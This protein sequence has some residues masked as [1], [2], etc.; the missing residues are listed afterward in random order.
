MVVYD[1]S[2]GAGLPD[3]ARIDALT[4]VSD[5][6]SQDEHQAGDAQWQ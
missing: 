1:R 6:R 4:G 5:T 3:R 2:A